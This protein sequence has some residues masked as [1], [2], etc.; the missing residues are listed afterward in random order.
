MLWGPLGWGHD[1]ALRLVQAY[2]LA[3]AALVW[4]LWWAESGLVLY[5]KTLG[6]LQQQGPVTGAGGEGR[7]GWSAL[8]QHPLL[9]CNKRAAFA[10][11]YALGLAWAVG[12]WLMLPGAQDSSTSLLPSSGGG[13]G[14]LLLALHTGRRLLETH[15]LQPPSPAQV[16]LFHACAGLLFYPAA[17]LLLFLCAGMEDTR[18]PK[19]ASSWSFAWSGRM[20]AGSLLFAWASHGQHVCHVHLA[21]LRK[22]RPVSAPP[23]GTTST[24]A[25]PA[26]A[27]PSHPWW[28]ATAHPHYALELLLYASLACLEARF[29]P[30]LVWV[31]VDL[32]VAGWKGRQWYRATFGTRVPV[33]W[34]CVVPGVF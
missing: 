32:G 25:R 12:L 16:H 28:R 27:L 1:A 13:L 14:L 29:A 8:L 11:F 21:S 34:A 31:A 30:V 9:Y 3:T 15:L 17:A 6:S 4:G 23:A 7:R 2:F 19:P 10:R 18:E 22:V 5:G 20:L 26:Y 24:S 33:P